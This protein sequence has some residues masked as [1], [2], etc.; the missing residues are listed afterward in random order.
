MSRRI[1][2]VNPL[3]EMVAMQSALD[4]M[5]DNSFP[6]FAER[7]ES[8]FTLPVDVV[9]ND[10]T[11]TVTTDLPGVSVENIDVRLD[12]EYLIVEA[13]IPEQ[14]IEEKEGRTLIQERRYG[15]FSRRIHLPQ[16]V[17]GDKVD[18]N[19]EDGVLTLSLPKVP[20]VQPKL[21]AVKSGKKK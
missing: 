13:E 20:E 6:G 14:V 9:E 15:K 16:P 1:I 2:C 8:I 21:I 7:G 18:A 10:T 19:F 5:F 17:D 12:N 11:Y 4:R 3:R